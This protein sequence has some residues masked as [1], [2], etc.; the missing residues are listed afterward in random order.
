MNKENAV[1]F[2]EMLSWKIFNIKEGAKIHPD[3]RVILEKQPAA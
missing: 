2:D 1:F 3:E